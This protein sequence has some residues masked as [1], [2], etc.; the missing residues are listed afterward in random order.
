MRGRQQ[1][2]LGSRLLR[3]LPQPQHETNFLDVCTLPVSHSY[4]GVQNTE[5][6]DIF[7]N[8]DGPPIS[9]TLE[10]SATAAYPLR[11]AISPENPFAFRS[12]MDNLCNER[13]N[14]TD[15]PKTV[16]RTA[17]A[18]S[19]PSDANSKAYSLL[20]PKKSVYWRGKRIVIRFPP[21]P[22]GVLGPGTKIVAEKD[23]EGRPL[24]SL[25]L[26]KKRRT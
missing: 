7:N 12:A 2:S 4:T 17:E 22:Y 24:R 23:E 20:E 3:L 1:K 8:I 21:T 5:N 11:L 14:S 26:S 15:L 9:F 6:V 16:A 13:L 18:T 19:K 25:E 10:S